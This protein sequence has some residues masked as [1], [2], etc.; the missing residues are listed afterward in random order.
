MIHLLDA[1]GLLPSL[2]LYVIDPQT[3]VLTVLRN[4]PLLPNEI[5]SK[6]SVLVNEDALRAYR[7][8]VNT[9][10][11]FEFKEFMER[12]ILTKEVEHN[13][14]ILK[15][16]NFPEIENIELQMAEVTD[17]TK[18]VMSANEE[19]YQKLKAGEMQFNEIK[20]INAL[21]LID[22]AA[23]NKDWEFVAKLSVMVRFFNRQEPETRI[24]NP[25]LNE[26]NSTAWK[27]NSMVYHLMMDKM[28]LP[29]S[30]K[31]ESSWQE[32]ASHAMIHGLN[33]LQMKEKTEVS[34]NKATLSIGEQ[35]N[36]NL[37]PLLAEYILL[38]NMSTEVKSKHVVERL[39]L[40]KTGDSLL[41][42]NGC[43]GHATCLLITKTSPDTYK[44][45]QY[46]TGQGVDEWHPNL[47]NSN[48][49][50]TFHV[51]DDIPKESILNLDN[52]KNLF[53]DSKNEK[54]MDRIYLNV[55]GQLGKGGKILPPSTHIEDYEAKQASATCSMQSLMAFLRHQCMEMVVGSPAEK[56]AV[57]KMI[58]VEM[59]L[60]YNQDNLPNLDASIQNILPV[61]TNKLTAELNMVKI[62]QDEKRFN[63]GMNE[64]KEILHKLGKEDIVQQL[65]ERNSE[66]NMARYATLRTAST[67]LSAIWLEN[68]NIIF[69]E[70]T[71]HHEI[72]ELAL[73]KLEHKNTI[74]Q[75]LKNNV[76][77]SAEQNS[78]KKLS[79]ELYRILV[80]TPFHQVGVE[81]AIKYF[82]NEIPSENSPPPGMQQLLTYL[83][84]RRD[85]T[86]S[87][88]QKIIENLEKSNIELSKWTKDN[89]QELEK[90]AP[91]KM[92]TFD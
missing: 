39:S 1:N 54:T 68:P 76:A 41:V 47:K 8:I 85:R 38:A 25:Y 62:A 50:Q 17:Q 78:N 67:I 14:K 37:K 83:N 88:V 44:L 81:E 6:L 51:V 24:D 65:N 4:S 46:N 22:Y 9:S 18:N 84:H 33:N 61:I 72:L 74:I 7:E 45:T 80:A 36:N 58:K 29:E 48:R 31:Y 2:P 26:F 52:W 59:L 28:A 86:D 57:Y 82:G 34:A 30:K 60:N 20:G 79:Y 32:I 12:I 27:A 63:N 90:S 19:L 10:K 91:I 13:L 40:M 42:P 11:E 66:T 71:K 70:N 69:T 35:L 56:E 75:N 64:I 21:N 43:N 73:A 53:N 3:S 55:N 23:V 77:L 89:W 87:S 92:K 16:N 5:K 49:F 15:E